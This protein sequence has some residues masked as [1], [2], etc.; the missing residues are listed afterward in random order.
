VRD[1]ARMF[2]DVAHVR[3]NALTGRYRRQDTRTDA[4]PTHSTRPEE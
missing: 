4:V 3:F 1:A 2:I